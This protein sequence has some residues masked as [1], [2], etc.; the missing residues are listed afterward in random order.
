MDVLNSKD[1]MVELLSLLPN[2]T[3]LMIVE[4]EHEA[5]VSTAVKEKED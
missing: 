5:V 4:N 3:T 1:T 2:K